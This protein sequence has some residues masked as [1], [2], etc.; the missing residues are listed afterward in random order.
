MCTSHAWAT[1]ASAGFVLAWPR[2]VRFCY[3]EK[4]GA[5]GSHLSDFRRSRPGR[6]H[7]SLGCFHRVRLGW[8]LFNQAL[9]ATPTINKA[10]AQ[11]PRLGHGHKCLFLR[12]TMCGNSCSRRTGGSHCRM[13]VR[14]VA[15]GTPRV[16]VILACYGS[17]R[18]FRCRFRPRHL[19]DWPEGIVFLNV[20]ARGQNSSNNN[21]SNN[22]SNS[23][24]NGTGKQ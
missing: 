20:L 19:R 24:D 13:P 12:C 22:G 14:H 21:D 6:A 1:M 11:V 4:I 23:N 16:K 15:C 5:G 2:R 8:Y 7:R 18:P 3:P 17:L 9:V 10:Q